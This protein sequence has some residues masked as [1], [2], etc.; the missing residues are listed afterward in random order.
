M[1]STCP[2][3]FCDFVCCVLF[4][5]GALFCVLSYCSTTATGYK[6][7]CSQN[8]NNNNNNNNWS[9]KF[10]PYSYSPTIFWLSIL[11]PSLQGY[12]GAC[13]LDPAI[14]RIVSV[15]TRCLAGITGTPIR[16]VWFPVCGSGGQLTSTA[17]G[18]SCSHARQTKRDSGFTELYRGSSGRYNQQRGRWNLTREKKQ[19]ESLNI[20]CSQ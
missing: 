17:D 5:C 19:G 16:I 18:Y 14:K 13:V 20:F 4:E 11:C 10:Y 2:Y 9:A 8:N 3:C 7:I 15:G 1:C 12:L 6:R